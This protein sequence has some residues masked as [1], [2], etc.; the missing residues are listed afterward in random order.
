LELGRCKC[1]LLSLKVL[2]VSVYGLGEATEAGGMRWEG[3]KVG[4]KGGNG[5]IINS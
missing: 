3:K 2:K 1:A 4:L 5:N